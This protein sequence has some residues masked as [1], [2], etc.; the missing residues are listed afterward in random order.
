MKPALYINDMLIQLYITWL[1]HDLI[2]K[3]NLITKNLDFIKKYDPENYHKPGTIHVFSTHF[4][5]KLTN[6]HN[7]TKPVAMQKV[8]DHF[9]ETYYPKIKRWTNK[10][11]IFEMETVLIPMN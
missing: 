10:V 9:E 4:W 11:N 7:T 5:E 2:L 6:R 8:I 1:Q 3:N